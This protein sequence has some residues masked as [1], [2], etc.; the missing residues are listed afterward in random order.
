[1]PANTRRSPNVGTMLANR[2]RRWPNI[3][4]AL[5]ER[6]VFAGICLCLLIKIANIRSPC[7]DKV[8]IRRRLMIQ[9]N[10]NEWGRLNWAK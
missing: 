10:E 8:L 3:V 5:G 4:P 1:M 2:L 9:L 6:L 7:N